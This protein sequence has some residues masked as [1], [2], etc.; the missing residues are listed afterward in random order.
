MKFGEILEIT[1]TDVFCQNLT[2]NSKAT[3]V[4]YCLDNV[5]RIA[6]EFCERPVRTKNGSKSAPNTVSRAAEGFVGIGILGFM[7]V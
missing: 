7:G 5:Q 2:K 1:F 3:K 4:P 6:L